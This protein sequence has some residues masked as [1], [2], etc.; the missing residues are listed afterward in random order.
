MDE[1]KT[2]KPPAIE[3]ALFRIEKFILEGDGRI[4]PAAED[5]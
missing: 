5:G 1:G 4:D 2:V 3:D